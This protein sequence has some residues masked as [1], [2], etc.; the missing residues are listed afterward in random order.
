MNG[1]ENFYRYGLFTRIIHVANHAYIYD[2]LYIIQCIIIMNLIMLKIYYFL[3][4]SRLET[5][6]TKEF[7]I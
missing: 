6:Y 4:I 5:F 2:F 7:E 3:V 1:V